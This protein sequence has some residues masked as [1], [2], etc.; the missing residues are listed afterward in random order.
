MRFISSDQVT[1]LLRVSHVQ[2]P[3][4]ATACDRLSADSLSRR[5]ISPSL[6]CVIVSWATAS[7]GVPS[8]GMRVMRTTNQRCSLG[9]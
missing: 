5:A 2:C 9:L 8:P 6:R 1:V 7:R 3:T 4:C